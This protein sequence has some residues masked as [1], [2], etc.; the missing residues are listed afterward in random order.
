MT[1]APHTAA[2]LRPAPF[3]AGRGFSP[4]L[5]VW[6][7]ALSALIA[8][9]TAVRV[10][11]GDDPA[12]GGPVVL[13]VLFINLALVG[14]LAVFVGARVLRLARWRRRDEPAPRL[15]L[16]LAGFLSFAAIIPAIIVAV[17]VGAVFLR[18]L[19]AWFSERVGSVVENVGAV[20]NA[21]LAEEGRDTRDD[22]RATAL[23]LNQP[24]VAEA[25]RVNRITYASYLRQQAAFRGFAAAYVVDRS[26]ATLAGA[27]LVDDIAYAPPSLEEFARA[28]EGEIPWT[29]NRATGRVRLLY[30]LTGYDDAYLHVMRDLDRTIIG[31][32]NRAEESLNAYRE[33]AA[34][35]GRTELAL[36]LL[37]L[38]TTLLVMLGAAW[39]GLQAAN[40]VVS[41][42]GRLVRASQRVR[43]GDLNARVTFADQRDELAF[44]GRAF[45][46]MTRQLKTQ[47]AELLDAK[48]DAERRRRFTEAVLGGVSAGV[49]GV[50]AAD[51]VTIANRSALA[52]LDAP[53][54]A[55][56]HGQ[57]VALA[58]PELARFVREAREARD[59]VSGGQI[60]LERAGMALTLNVRADAAKDGG[61][62]VVATFDDITRLVSAQRNAAWRDV[63]RRIAHEIKNPLT[64]IQLAAERLRRKYSG[65]IDTDPDVF[66]RCTE[67]IVRQVS[68]IGRM[69]DEFSSFARMPEPKL[70]RVEL[71][72]VVRG[73]VFTQRVASPE[74]VCEAITPAAPVH[75]TCDERLIAQ[76]LANVLKNAVESVNERM[77]ADPGGRG[78][79]GRVEARLD[80]DGGRAVVTVADNGVGWPAAHR[81]RLMEPYMTTREKG[82]GLG[83]SIT[84]RV[85]EDHHGRLEL[86][87]RKDG[88]AG[89]VVRLVVPLDASPSETT[90]W[91]A[92]RAQASG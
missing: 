47:R 10:F 52:L 49:M 28:D 91:S 64:P 31:Q 86:A 9:S 72:E 61:G 82:T 80:V 66:A 14:C 5:F 20:A 29:I 67:T 39:L 60:S 6:A 4:P 89:A 65:E 92:D 19:D 78:A 73:A 34:S 42:I 85:M 50:D 11:M 15:H 22:L 32:L 7:F 68:D 38:E 36:G 37:Y 35:R 62:A 74:I 88:G 84:S 87:D 53:E 16:R 43:D 90:D 58:A 17:F 13:S 8:L 46:E 40:R 25:L 3:G 21:Y 69:V 81:E 48:E 63:A 76:A 83:L 77:D 26:G 56:L 23:D 70:K 45:N 30:H 27:E 54:E 51:R 33:A 12:G 79:A 55:T 75:V 71:G 41:P 2:R 44:L 24:E 1:D 18:V 59:G 57:E